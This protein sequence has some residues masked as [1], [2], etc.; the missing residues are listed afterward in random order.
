M[1]SGGEVDYVR[2][3]LNGRGEAVGLEQLGPESTRLHFEESIRLKWPLSLFEGRIQ[4][5]IA[6]YNRKTML[7]MAEWLT[8]HPEYAA[9]SG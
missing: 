3:A 2:D 7:S 9:S 4:K 1:D 5:F 8:E 6:D